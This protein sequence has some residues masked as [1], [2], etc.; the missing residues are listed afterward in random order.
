[1][2]LCTFASFF[3]PR[4]SIVVVVDTDTKNLNTIVDPATSA[5]TSNSNTKL[6]VSASRF[7]FFFSRTIS[8]LEQRI[9]F[10]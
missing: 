4:P 5:L 6:H 2:N 3:V 1:M 10:Y 7:Y 8:A 9:P